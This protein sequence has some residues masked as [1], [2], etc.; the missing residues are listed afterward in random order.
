MDESMIDET[1]PYDGGDLFSDEEARVLGCLVEKQMTTPD[2][3]PMSLNG[4]TMA[5]N[6][7]SNRHPVV[8]YSEALVERTLREL[9]DQGAARMVHRPGDRVVKYRH[10]LGDHLEMSDPQL[11]LVAVLMLRGPQTPGELRQRT[12][13]YVDFASL[14]ELETTLVDLVDA[15]SVVRLDRQPGQ[16]EP[17]FVEQLSDRGVRSVS[18]L[19][20]TRTIAPPA[21][22]D[23]R[24]VDDLRSEI[25]Q[26]RER[27]EK[28]LDQLGVDD[29]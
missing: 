27:F 11:A 7:K 13:R 26:L 10:A 5:A 25:A 20:V 14:A 29:V 2:Q 18:G 1:S 17:R 24:F 6:Q 21:V 4:V 22:A 16:K 12:Q 8:D 9:S 23:D 19:D 3:Y 28:L 15:G